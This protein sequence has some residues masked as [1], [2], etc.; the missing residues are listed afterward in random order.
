MNMLTNISLPQLDEAAMI[1]P[2]EE[3]RPEP[4]RAAI[5][6]GVDRARVLR[7]QAFLAAAGRLRAGLKR[8]FGVDAD[9]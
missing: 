8:L 6:A 3:R 5:Q 7:A 9:R 2:K 1:S 4:S